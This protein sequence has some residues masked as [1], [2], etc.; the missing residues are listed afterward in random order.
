MQWMKR[1]RSARRKPPQAPRDGPGETLPVQEEEVCSALVA[2]DSLCA[3]SLREREVFDLLIT[4]DKMRIIGERLAIKTST[5]NGYCKMIYRKLG[6][7]SRVE[8]VLRYG[9]AERNGEPQGEE[10]KDLG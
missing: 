7:N 6:V 3:L 5:V 8:L 2:D 1:F 4:G 10:R 9:L